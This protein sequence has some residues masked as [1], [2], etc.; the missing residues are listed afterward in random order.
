MKFAAQAGKRTTPNA[1]IKDSEPSG[2]FSYPQLSARHKYT[3]QSE[4][5]SLFRK[6]TKN[7]TDLLSKLRENTFETQKNTLKSIIY[8]LRETYY[9]AFLMCWKY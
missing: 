8:L 3:C 4:N 9:G 7:I 6:L 5:I 2:N 1:F